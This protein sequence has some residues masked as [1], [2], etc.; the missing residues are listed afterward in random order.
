MRRPSLDPLTIPSPG[1]YEQATAAP[2]R[3]VRSPSR[4]E[5]RGLHSSNLELNLSNSRTHSGFSWDTRWTEELK[6]S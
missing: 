6:L 1:G 3:S 4:P 2:V 5:G